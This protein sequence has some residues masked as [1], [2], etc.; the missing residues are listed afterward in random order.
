MS[1]N[2]AQKPASAR[3]AVASIFDQAVGFVLKDQIEGGYVNDPRDPG[4]ETNFGISKRSYPHVNIRDLTREDAVAIYKRDYWDACKC[5]ELPPEIA[6]AVFD[7]AVNQGA[8][9]AIR[10]LQKALRVTSDGIIGPKTMAAA[11]K[12]DA[13]EL[14][15]D[16]LSWRLR[17]YANTA[18][19]ITYMRGWSK[20]V[21]YLLNF[22]TCD[23]EVPA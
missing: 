21:L 8:G 5:E 15:L 2:K 10:L 22:L 9:I 12:A 17:R 20:R 4:G 14:V 1:S 11:R 19:A 18:N 7:C 3:Q 16:F 13:M 23:I 6:V